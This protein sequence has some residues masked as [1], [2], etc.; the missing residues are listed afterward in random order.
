[1]ATKNVMVCDQCASAKGVNRYSVSLVKH[2]IGGSEEGAVAIV[3]HDLDYCAF[4]VAR[5]VTYVDRAA[6]IP[7]KVR[8]E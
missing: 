7:P 1:M 4:C 2:D 3:K 6:G 5:A 8:G